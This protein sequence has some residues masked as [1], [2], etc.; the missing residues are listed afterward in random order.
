MAVC[1]VGIRKLLMYEFHEVCHVFLCMAELGLQAFQILIEE[2]RGVLL[3][4][5]LDVLDVD[6]GRNGVD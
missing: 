5:E 2:E 1:G 4:R 6:G 3:H